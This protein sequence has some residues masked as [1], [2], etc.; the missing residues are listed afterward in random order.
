[1]R[2]DA[3]MKECMRTGRIAATLLFVLALTAAARGAVAPGSTIEV[4]EGDTWSKAT[5]ISTEGEN[6][7]VKYED[8]TTELVTPDRVRAVAGGA[9]AAGITQQT[10]IAPAAPGEVKNGAAAGGGSVAR[11]FSVDEAIEIKRG[12]KW[13]EAHIEQISP[14]WIFVREEKDQ[15]QT[16]WAEP[17]AIRVAGSAYDIEGDGERFRR[18]E[19]GQVAPAERPK[20][21]PPSV[22]DQ[23]A[24][25]SDADRIVSGEDLEKTYDTASFDN[26]HDPAASGDTTLHISATQPSVPFAAWALRGTENRIDSILPCLN[27]VKTAVASFPGSFGKWTVVI[28]T[29]L[30]GH[31]QLDTR[32]LHIADLKPLAAADEGD[33]LLTSYKDQN[34]QLWKWSEHGYQLAVNLRVD[35]NDMSRI[36][37]AA[38]VAPDKAVVAQNTGEVFLV[39]LTQKTVISSIKGSNTAKVFV[40][41][42][43][44]VIGVITTSA[45]ALL[46]RPDFSVF[47]EF[48]D[49]GTT[50]N[51]TVDPT[52]Q[53]AAYVCSTG[54][55]RIVKISDGSPIGIVAVGAS[56]NGRLDLVDDKFLLV[57]HAT[58]YDIR[59]GIPVWIYKMPMGVSVSPLIS[60]QFLIAAAGDNRTAIAV[61]S[62]PDQI[63]RAAIKNATPDRF[64]LVPGKSIKLDCDFSAFGDQKDKARDA[65]D[66]VITKAGMKI[67]ESDQP[68]HFTMAIAAGPTE[69]RQYAPSI[70]AGPFREITAVDVPSNILTA[71]LTFKGQPV[72]S[73]EIR[74][75][76]GGTLR[77]APGGTFQDAANDAAKPNASALGSLN[78]PSYLPIGA[79]PGTPA[80]LGASDLQDRRFVPER[81]APL[82]QGAPS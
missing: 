82:R 5:V 22:G 30:L 18:A 33:L 6:V 75:G 11:A 24:V 70:F 36:T 29:N 35:T 62:I 67:S 40:H 4:R 39:D 1:M 32:S 17:W 79:K 8:G 65:L 48:T 78:F 77:K 59:S 43:G 53:W 21:S 51:V 69:K 14:P 20:K 41:P 45:T 37:S 16:C 80:A 66:D 26:S 15:N 28:R 19:P 57:D 50:S 10:P 23:F 3:C 71:T 13:L 52:G 27:S 12:D 61:A 81:P 25:A 9:A 42:S 74:F 73:Q 38:F 49:A 54:A 76:A 63:G 55:V 47:A 44:Q 31:S 2:G 60:G 46:L 7:Q 58:A 64:I 72:W 68:F 34:L 56:F